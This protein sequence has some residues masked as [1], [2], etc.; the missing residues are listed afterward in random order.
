VVPPVQ[1]NEIASCEQDIL[2][3]TQG[4]NKPVFVDKAPFVGTKD[5]SSLFVEIQDER[6]D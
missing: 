4:F 5:D 1:A 6:I 3:E 2:V